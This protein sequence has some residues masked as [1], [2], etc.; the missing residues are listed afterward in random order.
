[1]SRRVGL[2]A[3]YL[4]PKYGCAQ[5]LPNNQEANQIGYLHGL[6]PFK[7]YLYNGSD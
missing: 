1:L 5:L 2:I 7:Q 4:T 3:D 6:S